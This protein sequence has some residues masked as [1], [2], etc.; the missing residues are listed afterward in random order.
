LLH[1]VL[2]KFPNDLLPVIPDLCAMIA[3][4]LTDACPEVKIK[5]SEFISGLSS[6]LNKVIGPHSKAII[7]SLCGNLKH[8]H[9]KIRKIS[10]IVIL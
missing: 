6:K 3:K 5:L 10:L 4:L 2:D 1:K 9:N 8:A 7:I